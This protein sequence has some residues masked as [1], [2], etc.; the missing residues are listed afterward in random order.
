M[1]EYIFTFYLAKSL[2]HQN[3]HTPQISD[4]MYLNYQEDIDVIPD[5]FNE[6]N[7]S[8]I[9]QINHI[10]ID[11]QYAD[12][13][14][15]ITPNYS[16]ILKLKIFKNNKISI[17]TKT[18]AFKTYI[19][20]IFLYNSETWTTTKQLNAQIDSFQRCLIRKFILN[21]KWPDVVKNEQ[22]YSI[23]K[24][25][26]WS[27]TI[28]LRRIKWFG[29]IARMDANTPLARTSICIIT[30]YQIKRATSD[31]MGVNDKR[32]IQKDGHNMG[33]SVQTSTRRET[34]GTIFYKFFI[35]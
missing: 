14:S 13:I 15:K 27:E 8:T 31:Y 25:K 20:S 23:T 12:D 4:H 6:H 32:R 11:Q 34:M 17:S 21:V 7:Y 10:D 2:D 18:S 19:Y 26:P 1:V 22:V 35:Q 29:K 3:N 33:F 9:T 28:K 24:L 30:I 5:H 16:A